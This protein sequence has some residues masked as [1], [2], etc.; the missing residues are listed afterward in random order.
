[1]TFPGQSV[2]FTPDTE[3][4]ADQGNH[5]LQVQLGKLLCLLEVLKGTWVRDCAQEHGK[6]K[7]HC[8]PASSSQPSITICIL[9]EVWDSLNLNS[10]KSLHFLPWRNVNESS[11]VRV[12]W[13]WMNSCSNSRQQWAHQP[14]GMHNP[15]GQFFTY[16]TGISKAHQLSRQGCGRGNTFIPC[17]GN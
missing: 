17:G 16:Q 9:S 11:L 2:W 10:F 1:M 13:G 15:T 5:V 7:A 8:I 14:R 3:A 12:S 6:V 4:I